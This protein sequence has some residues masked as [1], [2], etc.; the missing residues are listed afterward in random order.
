MLAS[1]GLKT[2]LHPTGEYQ[3][4]APVVSHGLQ[5]Q[6]GHVH[7]QT[8]PFDRQTEVPL[9]HCYGQPCNSTARRLP[10]ATMFCWRDTACCSSVAAE[11]T[12]P[13][14]EPAGKAARMQSTADTPAAR[15]PH[16]V[17]TS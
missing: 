17:D 1:V 6:P 8:P 14:M 11:G 7:A 12:A 16:T 13:V 4:N 15:W 9:R 2:Q 3:S 10:L 5:A